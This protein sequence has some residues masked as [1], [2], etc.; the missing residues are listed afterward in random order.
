MNI[1]DPYELFI[2]ISILLQ[3]ILRA[4][5]DPVTWETSRKKVDF[6]HSKLQRIEDVKRKKRKKKV[7]WLKKM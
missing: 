1:Y 6:Q 2:I 3:L 7:E 5:Q 4:D